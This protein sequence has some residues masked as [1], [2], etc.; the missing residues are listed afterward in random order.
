MVMEINGQ[1]IDVDVCDLQMV[2][3]LGKGV[4]GQVNKMRHG[5]SGAVMAVKVCVKQCYLIYNQINNSVKKIQ[6]VQCK[7]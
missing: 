2:E 4:N 6:F 1:L 7:C 3:P 5:P